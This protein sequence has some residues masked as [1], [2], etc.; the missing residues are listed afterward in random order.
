M[1]LW[2]YIK[3]GKVYMIRAYNSG[4]YADVKNKSSV[5]GAHINQYELKY[6]ENQ[7]FYF[8]EYND[9]GYYCIR[10]V[11]TVKYISVSEDY[12]SI[13]TSYIV[14][15]LWTTA[16]VLKRLFLS[17]FFSFL[18]AFGGEDLPNSSLS[19]HQRFIWGYDI[20][21]NKWESLKAVLP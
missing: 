16:I 14:I 8:T 6:G 17:I 1:K 9:S 20:L 4:K 12:S 2:D 7:Y 13:N 21:N 3:S 5:V 10:P 19:H 11:Y 18:A 15:C